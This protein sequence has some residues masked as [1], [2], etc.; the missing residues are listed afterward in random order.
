MCKPSSS[1]FIPPIITIEP[2]RPGMGNREP[3][4]IDMGADFPESLC[5]YDFKERTNR[6]LPQKQVGREPSDVDLYAATTPGN[7]R[8]IYYMNEPQRA[9]D[10]ERSDTDLWAATTRGNTRNIDAI[11]TKPVVIKEPSDIDLWAAVEIAAKEQECKC[12]ACHGHEERD[13]DATAETISSSHHSLSHHSGGPRNSSHQHTA[14]HSHH[15]DKARPNVRLMTTTKQW[16]AALQSAPSTLRPSRSVINVSNH[17]HM[18]TQAR[19]C[20]AQQ[21]QNCQE[22]HAPPNAHSNR[23]QGQRMHRALDCFDKQRELQA[24]GFDGAVDR[25]ATRR[26]P[27]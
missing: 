4:D 11:A 9:V 6:F 21:Q 14:S 3:S 17:T 19:R 27:T 5:G 25:N 26:G 20:F 24:F 8:S 15:Y 22:I 1:N 10:R 18:M 23:H 7:G 12:I 13:E 16:R 2:F